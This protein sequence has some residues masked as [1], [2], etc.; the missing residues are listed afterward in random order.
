MPFLSVNPP[1][2]T[3]LDPVCV[4]MK[5]VMPLL[6]HQLTTPSSP[7]SLTSPLPPCHCHSL[8]SS[9][10]PSLPSCRHHLVPTRL[11]SPQIS[12]RRRLP[13]LVCATSARPSI[14]V[15]PSCHAHRAPLRSSVLTKD[16]HLGRMDTR[17]GI[18][19]C[20]PPSFSY[21]SLFYFR[22]SLPL[23]VP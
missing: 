9:S 10:S 17:Y 16:H 3:C 19:A 20:H 18:I 11:A 6:R 2:I 12:C 22:L 21:V 14:P 13:L 8:S 7:S 15:K 4:L 23:V 5:H 1:R